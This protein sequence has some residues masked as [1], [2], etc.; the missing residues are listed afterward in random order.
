MKYFILKPDRKFN[1]G[2]IMKMN[3]IDCKLICKE[4]FHKIPKRQVLSMTMKDTTLFPELITVPYFLVS[5][6]MMSVIQMYGDMIRKRDLM[7]I[8]SAVKIVKRYFVV[9]FE[10]LT[11][12][13]IENKDNGA[14]VLHLKNEGRPLRERNIFETELE[15]KREIIIN[16]DFAESILRRDAFGIDLEEIEVYEQETGGIRL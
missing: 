14:R 10:K 15:G 8:D 4:E 5:E 12:D 11:C 13:T 6:K 9:L 2:P 1:D 7:L 16:L 3:T